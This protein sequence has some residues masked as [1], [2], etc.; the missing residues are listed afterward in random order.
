MAGTVALLLLGAALCVAAL[1]LYGFYRQGEAFVQRVETL[2]VQPTPTPRIDIRAVI[3]RQVRGASELTTALYSM[4]TIVAQSQA[5]ELLGVQVGE[6][7]MIYVAYGEVRAGVDLSEID[8]SNVQVVSDTVT[9]R[10]P[11]PKILD[12]KIDV[13]RSYVYDFD[14]S[15]FG[16]VDPTMQSRA[17]QL[18]LEKI[19]RAACENGI[20]EE[21][22]T[23]AEIAVRALLEAASFRRVR[24]IT[25]PPPPSA[26][27]EL[28]EM[29][30]SSP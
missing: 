26:C 3:V 9:I 20:L 22:N 27:P 5:R 14:K 1:S 13:E 30:A 25:T 2:F 6:T 18:A 10:L 17:E 7:K 15:L 19:R 29:P 28:E 12:A 23:R 24:V 8:A 11:P 16:P 4:E 21:A